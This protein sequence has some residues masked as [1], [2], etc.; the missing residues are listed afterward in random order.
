[1][2]YLYT[3][4]GKKVIVIDS[5]NSTTY[6]VQ[7]VFIKGDS[8]YVDGEQFAVEKNSL[9]KSITKSW[10]ETRLDT[11]NIQIPELIREKELELRDIKDRYTKEIRREKHLLTDIKALN[12]TYDI[13]TLKRLTMFI[14]GRVEYVVFGGYGDMKIVKFNDV[15]FEEDSTFGSDDLKLITL[16]GNTNGDLNFRMNRYSDGSASYDNDIYPVE[17]FED[18]V[19]YIQNKVDKYF[20]GDNFKKTNHIPDRFIKLI[21]EYG[22]KI[23]VDI[24]RA[25]YEKKLV[26]LD[27]A[28]DKAETEFNNKVTRASEIIDLIENL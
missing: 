13:D 22:I 15:M 17:S 9:T 23:D 2:E 28:V 4:E 27:T 8:E 12:K 14:S 6:I 10:Q 25:Y 5:L 26:V 24:V 3:K 19:A 16:F 7:E 1:M 21:D 11:L 18:G 20:K